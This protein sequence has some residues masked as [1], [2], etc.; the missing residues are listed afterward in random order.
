[1]SDRKKKYLEEIFKILSGVDD[2]WIL[3]VIYR[4]TVNMTKKEDK[5]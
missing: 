3:N 4:F 5:A 2:L 1:M